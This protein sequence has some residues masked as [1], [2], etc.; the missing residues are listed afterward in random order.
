MTSIR[1]SI[2]PLVVSVSFSLLLIAGVCTAQD[3]PIDMT[4]FD[5]STRIQDDLFNHVN[6]TWLEKTKIPDDKSNYGSFG[7]LADMSKERIKTIVEEVS[8]SDH[9]KGTDKQKVADMYRSFMNEERVNGLGATPIQSELTKIDSIDTK[10]KLIEHF[11][12]HSRIGVDSPIGFYVSQD[13]G[14]ATEYICNLVQS[15]TTLPDRDYYLKDDENSTAARKALQAYIETIAGLAGAD[16]LKANADKVVELEKALAEIQWTRVQ[17]RDA[18]KR[19]NKMSFAELSKLTKS[20]V[21]W[22]AYFVSADVEEKPADVNVNTPSY[23]QGLADLIETTPQSTWNAYLKYRVI[24]SFAAYLSQDFVDA[25]FELYEKQLQGIEVSED[26][27]KRAVALVAGGRGFGTLGEVVGKLYVEKHFKPEAKAKMETLVNNLL[28]AFEASID[29]LEWMTDETKVK[30]KEKLSKITTKIGYPNRWRDYSQLTVNAEDLFGNVYRS[31]IV[32]HYRNIR[33]LGQPID[34]E[35][36]GMTPQTVNAYYSP[37]KNEIVFPAAILQPPFFDADAPEALNYGGIGAVIGHEIS[38]AFDDQGSKYDGD[39]NLNNWWTDQDREAF[40]KLTQQLVAQYATYEPLPGKNVD[41]RLTLGENIADL[42]GLTISHKALTIA[43]QGKPE[44]M[45]AGWN[46][47]Q[48][49]FVGWSRVW[50]RKYRDKEMVKRLLTDPHS[51][52]RY[53]ANGP[54]TNIEAFYQAFDV[55]PGDKLYKPTE[56]RIAIW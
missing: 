25:Q 31:N 24:D 20:N 11:G 35:E 54:V 22:V 16:D 7:I 45:V 42:S 4:A 1:F 26:R 41:G 47:D 23:F 29:D 38:H 5:K 13:V 36:W 32:E 19:Y 55:K 10:Q 40:R 6:G 46:S 49:F 48:L 3:S 28:K 52:S 56:E 44:V 33:K 51:P 15:G 37:T 8:E 27:W 50:Q 12:Y 9:P 17:L 53:R 34:R 30:A 43:R 18:N 39:G 2:R 14:N 21:D